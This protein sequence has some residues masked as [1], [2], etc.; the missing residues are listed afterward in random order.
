MR[1]V[2]LK[3]KTLYKNRNHLN[4]HNKKPFDASKYGEHVK[5]GQSTTVTLTS[6][7]SSDRPLCN[8]E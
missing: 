8:T 7:N 4:Q 2:H 6:V 5:S 3:I 1:R